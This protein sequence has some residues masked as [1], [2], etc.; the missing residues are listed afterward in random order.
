MSK[1]KDDD[2]SAVRFEESRRGRRPI[3]LGQ[4]KANK[5]RLAS[6]RTYLDLGT[7]DEFVRAM[8]DFGLRV[9]SPKFLAALAVWREHRSQRRTY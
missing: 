4:H 3:D 9:G 5:E 8:R 7:Q 2:I 1:Q 6:F